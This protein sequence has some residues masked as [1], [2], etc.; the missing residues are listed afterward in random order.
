MDTIA[1]Y[2]AP[3]VALSGGTAITFTNVEQQ[4]GVYKFLDLSE[5]DFRLRRSVLVTARDP[6]IAVGSPNGYTQARTSQVVVVPVLLANGKIT[7]STVRIETSFDIEVP[8]AD[9]IGILDSALALAVSTEGRRL[10]IKQA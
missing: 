1:S 8:E 4:R 6:K 2:K 5:S 7:T 3:T 10:L 9:R